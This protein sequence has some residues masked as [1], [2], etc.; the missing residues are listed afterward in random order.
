[1]RIR[2]IRKTV[3]AAATALALT[4][5]AVAAPQAQAIAGGNS[6][7]NP[8]STVQIFYKG[9]FA[10]SG[11]LA[12]SRYIF[13][14]LSCLP[15]HWQLRDFTVRAGDYRLGRGELRQVC[16]V[17]TQ[18]VEEPTDGD[19]TK[20][21]FS[22][23]A[24]VQLSEDVRS[25]SQF[26]ELSPELPRIGAN[27]SVKGWGHGGD[28]REATMRVNSLDQPLHGINEGMELTRVTGHARRDVGAPVMS[29]N[30]LVGVVSKWQDTRSG[31]K[32]T[33]GGRGAAQLRLS[34]GSPHPFGA[35]LLTVKPGPGSE[36]RRDR[37][38]ASDPGHTAIRRS[39]AWGP[40]PPVCQGRLFGRPAL[41]PPPPRRCAPG[42][43][44]NPLA[45]PANGTRRAGTSPAGHVRDPSVRRPGR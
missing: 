10:C 16:G 7:N 34:Q 37:R 20:A 14:A 2:T 6:S 12:A 5:S 28:L 27:V 45:R 19:W 18:P 32:G 39:S 36:A 23:I 38:R 17:G 22:D 41:T 35:H 15:D 13:T 3:P 21:K 11:A 29:G 31:A 4:I 1:M 26:V 44:G 24:M 40:S 25:T 8:Q 43:A 33:W 42:R 9:E 30:K